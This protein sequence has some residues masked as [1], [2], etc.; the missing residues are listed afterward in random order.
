MS[1]QLVLAP[2]GHPGVPA[3]TVI[4]TVEV[5]AQNCIVPDGSTVAKH[6]EELKSDGLT[7]PISRLVAYAG[8]H[9]RGTAKDYWRI[10]DGRACIQG[11]WQDICNWNPHSEVDSAG[12]SRLVFNV[13]KNSRRQANL[14]EVMAVG[15]GLVV[16]TKIYDMPYRFWRPTPGLLRYDF[17]GPAAGGAELQLEVRGRSGG[18]LGNAQEEVHR[19]FGENP[20]MARQLGAIFATRTSADVSYPDLILLDPKKDGL[21]A[22]LQHQQYRSL[23]EHYAFFFLGQGFTDFGDRLRTLASVSDTEFDLFLANGDDL[24][25]KARVKRVSFRVES[26]TFSGTAFQGVAWPRHIAPPTPDVDFSSGCFYF[27]IWTKAVDALCEGQLEDLADMTTAEEIYVD[28]AK[29]YI[30]LDDATA[31]AWAPTNEQLMRMA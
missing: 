6:L 16:A 11:A 25:R 29:V 23:L 31:L 14:A 9:Y 27:G 3:D 7:V 26:Y 24:L 28:G 15:V 19:K 2:T 22:Q 12:K 8:I 20:S 4:L 30:I 21:S 10:G 5:E 17:R 13:N 1:S 18:K